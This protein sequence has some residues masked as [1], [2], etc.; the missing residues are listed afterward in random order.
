MSGQ[1]DPKEGEKDHGQEN[2]GDLA[3]MITPEPAF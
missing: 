3:S 2:G 1:T